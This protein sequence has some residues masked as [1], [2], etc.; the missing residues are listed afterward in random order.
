MPDLHVTITFLFVNSN[1]W[2]PTLRLC[3]FLPPSV[4]IYWWCLP[5]PSYCVS[6]FLIL[7]FLLHL[8]PGSLLQSRDL[9]SL[10]FLSVS[11]DLQIFINSMSTTIIFWGVLL[12]SSR[13]LKPIPVSF[14]LVLGTFFSFWPE[15]FQDHVV[16]SL[17]RAWN[18]PFFLEALFPFVGMAFRTEI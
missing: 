17:L 3:T 10:L 8:F 14:W 2:C 15:I 16:H 7:S 12:A 18:E 4:S 1:L 5:E 6:D 13:L 11:V 9:P